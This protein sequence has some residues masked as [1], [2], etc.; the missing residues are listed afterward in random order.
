MNMD[1]PS[2][3]RGDLHQLLITISY[4]T[5]KFTI[6]RFAFFKDILEIQFTRNGFHLLNKVETTPGELDFQNI[7]E[8]VQI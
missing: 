2:I 7:F 3:N 4:L 6:I 5:Y 8:K 1:V